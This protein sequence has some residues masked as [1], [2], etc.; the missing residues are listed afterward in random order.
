MRFYLQ[1]A[2]LGNNFTSPIK[3]LKILMKSSFDIL[4]F[5]KITKDE[6][7]LFVVNDVLIFIIFSS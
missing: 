2:K 5:D 3:S 1:T 4:V 6:L 7:E